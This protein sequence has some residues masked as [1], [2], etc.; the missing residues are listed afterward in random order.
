[1]SKNKIVLSNDGLKNFFKLPEKRKL[2]YDQITSGSTGV[3]V[4]F[5]LDTKIS[6]SFDYTYDGN[7]QSIREYVNRMLE[8]SKRNKII[9]TDKVMFL[10]NSKFPRISFNRYS[11]KAKRVQVAHKATKFVIGDELS[12][13]ESGNK[14]HYLLEG[15]SLK[16]PLL[17]DIDYYDMSEFIDNH[18]VKAESKYYE[19]VSNNRSRYY[20][21]RK[22][23]NVIKKDI[24]K[25]LRTQ[26]SDSSITVKQVNYNQLQLDNIPIKET[27]DFLMTSPDISK[28][29]SDSNV[30]KYVSKFKGELDEGN[31]EYL[32]MALEA[33]RGDPEVAMQLLSQ[34]TMDPDNAL[35]HALFIN[36][37]YKAINRIINHKVFKSIDVQNFVTQ[38]NLNIYLHDTYG[39]SRLQQVG[40]VLNT[41]LT[42]SEKRILFYEKVKDKVEDAVR[43][44]T[45]LT[46]DSLI[47]ISIDYEETSN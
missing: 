23:D 19:Y 22:L 7:S 30:N 17:L 12:F 44:L 1:M 5:T 6:D 41:V 27:F 38:S 8:V 31:Y 20:F 39:N 3:D 11:D 36:L 40:N 21:N 25:D 45:G 42:T 4:T 43:E 26:L 10:K 13:W 35:L 46:E 32:L 29:T 18:T 14:K 33:E 24:L 9:D 34:L 16:E 15:D 2:L 28:I 37:D 47:K